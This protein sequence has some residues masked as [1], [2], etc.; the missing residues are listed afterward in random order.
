[1]TD[2]DAEGEINQPTEALSKQLDNRVD[3]FVGGAGYKEQH[4]DG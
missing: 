1:V 2:R 4:D 3:Q